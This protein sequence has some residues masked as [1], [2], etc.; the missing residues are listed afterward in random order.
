VL[1]KILNDYPPKGMPA[2]ACSTEREKYPLTRG[3]STPESAAQ[4]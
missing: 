2:E 4:V 3:I 1:A